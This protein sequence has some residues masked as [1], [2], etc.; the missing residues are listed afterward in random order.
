MDTMS[1]ILYDSKEEAAVGGFKLGRIDALSAILSS[2]SNNEAKHAINNVALYYGGDILWDEPPLTP[3]GNP[4]YP[5]T[6]PLRKIMDEK[7]HSDGG[8]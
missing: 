7:L 5:T 3:S 4:C 6:E 8:G 1:D 2:M